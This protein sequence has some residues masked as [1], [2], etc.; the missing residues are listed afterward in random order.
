MYN[1]TGEFKCEICHKWT[2]DEDYKYWQNKS[3]CYNCYQAMQEE[4]EMKVDKFLL[5]EG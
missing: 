1:P 5:K 2:A 4:T 3:V